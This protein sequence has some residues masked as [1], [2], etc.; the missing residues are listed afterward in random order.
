VHHKRLR[1]LLQSKEQQARQL[2][3]NALSAEIKA[4]ASIMVSILAKGVSRS[5]SEV[6][7]EIS[8]IPVVVREL[9]R[10]ISTIETSVSF[11]DSRNV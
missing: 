3:S 7:G 2:K 5:S 10:L 1:K 4:V 11:V 9:A 6:F 8:R